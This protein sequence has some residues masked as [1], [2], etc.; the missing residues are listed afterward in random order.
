MWNEIE[1]KNKRLDGDI[2]ELKKNG[3]D[4]AY[5]ERD[6]KIALCK[7]A[8]EL[9]DS[10]MP[11]TLINLVIYG[12]DNIANLRCARDIAQVTYNATQEDINATKLQLRLIENQI[13]REWGASK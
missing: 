6:Y 10:G 2:G 8:L 7:K 1:D 3:Y 11:V 13:S 9:K 4:L 5:K 12:I